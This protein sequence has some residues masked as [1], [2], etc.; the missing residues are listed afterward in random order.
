M[1]KIYLI[2]TLGVLLSSCTK[3][4]EKNANPSTPN[5]TNQSKLFVIKQTD[6]YPSIYISNVITL[7]FLNS[8]ITE[9]SVSQLTANDY[10]DNIA[11]NRQT[12]EIIAIGEFKGLNFP[13]KKLYK[14]NIATGLLKKIDVISTPNGFF[15]DLVTDNTGN[16]FAIKENDNPNITF[17]PQ[18]VKINQTTGEQSL[19]ASLSVNDYLDN[20]TYNSTTNEIIG[21]GQDKTLTISNRK[22]Y[23]INVSTGVVSIIDIAESLGTSFTDIIIDN[24]QNLYS[25]I[26]SDNPTSTIVPKIVKINQNTGV[27]TQIT[28]LNVKDYLDHFVFDNLTNEIIGIGADK[29]QGSIYDLK[30]FKINVTNGTILKSEINENPTAGFYSELLIR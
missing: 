26:Q 2:V 27:L 14:I 15:R 12:N 8:P 23:K 21:I 13:D 5:P 29:T 24:N 19:V 10:L 1:N 30:L 22:I 7:D 3:N 18:I 20:L 6:L 4:N 17:V 11:I 9:T 25:V 28:T 16:A